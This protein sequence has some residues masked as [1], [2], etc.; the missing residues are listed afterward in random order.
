MLDK[1]FKKQFK[2]QDNGDEEPA[3]LFGRYSDNNKSIEK[4][5]KWNESDALFKEKKFKESIVTFFD[6]LRDDD[7]ENVIHEP[8]GEGGTFQIYQGSKIIRGFYDKDTFEAEAVLASM[9][10]PSVPVMRRLLEMNFKLY[11]SRHA[12]NADKLSMLFDSNIETCNPSKLYY[13]LK[14]LATKAD[15]HDDLLV[16]DFTSLSPVG[17]EHIIEIPE[18]EKAI[19]FKYYKKWIRETLELIEKVDADKYSGGI[20]YLLLALAYRIDYL[21]VPEGKLLSEIEKI[22][23]IYFKKDERLVTEKNQE[24]MH[25]FQALLDK[26]KE[27]FYPYLFRAKYT[28][29]IV[30]PQSFKTISDAIYNAN[31]NINWYKENK[32]PGIAAQISEYGI[33]YCQFSY[34]LPKPITDLFHLFMM[35]N[36]PD[37]FAELGYKKQYYDKEKNEFDK[38][39]IIETI[40]EIQGAWQE[41]YPEMKFKTDK[42]K[43]DDLVSFNQSFTN[44]IEA[45]N[46]E[47]K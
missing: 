42:L 47:T 10:Q 23:E 18:E 13:G 2:R 8:N 32:Q 15:K 6:Y 40:N 14:E 9:P 20:A 38:D 3:V 25:G 11:Y 4:V 27:E 22:V 16:Q 5:E 21:V 24:M 45:L 37:F 33:A 35:I 41:K 28:F 44:E 36:Y 30:S 46:M 34:S 12:L 17:I 7:V 43:F 39:A 29:S 31:Q 1:I 26:S 19:K